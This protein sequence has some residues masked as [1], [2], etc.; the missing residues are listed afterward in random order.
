VPEFTFKQ[1][2]ALAVVPRLA[3]LLIRAL[4]ATLTYQDVFPA[5][6]VDP[7]P[8]DAIP[9]PTIYAFWHRSLLTCAHRFRNKDIA[10][11]ISRSF[12]GELI[13]RTVELLGFRAIRGSS[14]RGGATGLRQMAEAFGQGHRCA[15]TADGPRGPAMVA[16][17]GPAQLAQLVEAE[18]VGTFYALPLSTWTL[19]TWDKF[20]IPK[21]F[22]KVLIAFPLPVPASTPD[23][24]A[25]IQASLD[26]AVEMTQSGPV[27]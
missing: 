15:F 23:L 5:G 1:R 21:P 3:K 24:Q 4:G 10:I 6:A 18:W 26:L 7:V 25:A 8:G 27:N 14:S 17:P 20:L 9:G 11:L 16:K 12:D 2:V 19:K 13:A 22:S